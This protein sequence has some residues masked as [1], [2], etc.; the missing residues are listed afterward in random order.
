MFKFEA[1]SDHILTALKQD[2]SNRK[3][4]DQDY[5]DTVTVICNNGLVI[6]HKRLMCTHSQVL[7]K[8]LG[9]QSTDTAQIILHDFSREAVVDV[10]GIL[11]MEWEDAVFFDKEVME[12]LKTLGINVGEIEAKG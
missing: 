2:I 6:T 5:L 4:Q 10:L 12:L 11:G 3:K 1:P 7:R 8:I 9:Q